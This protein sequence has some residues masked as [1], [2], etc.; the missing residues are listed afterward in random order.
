MWKDKLPTDVTWNFCKNKC[1]T[2]NIMYR[3]DCTKCED[4][5]EALEV[6]ATDRVDYSYYGETARTLHVRASQHMRLQGCCQ[7]PP[8]GEPS[9]GQQV[10]LH[11]G[12]HL[13]GTWW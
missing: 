3:A 13:G 2:E 10:Q 11:V 12:P 1:M 4:R 6:P 7:E 5:Q 8:K 9:T